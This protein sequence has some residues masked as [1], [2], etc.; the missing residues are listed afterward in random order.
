M[1]NGTPCSITIPLLFPKLGMSQVGKN[2]RGFTTLGLYSSNDW[3]F[4]LLVLHFNTHPIENKNEFILK[5][6]SNSSVSYD[7]LSD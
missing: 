5:S 6:F 4:K 7:I 3:G 1:K 2:D